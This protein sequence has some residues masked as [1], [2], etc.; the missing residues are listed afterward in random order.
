MATPER[1]SHAATNPS[2]EPP[3]RRRLGYIATTDSRALAKASRNVSFALQAINRAAKA[4]SRAVHRTRPFV[5][6]SFSAFS[7]FSA[8][9]RNGGSRPRRYGHSM[10]ATSSGSSVSVVRPSCHVRSVPERS[11]RVFA[12]RG[13]VRAMVA[14]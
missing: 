13:A 6:L 3:G 14:V 4:S 7:A 5:P 2:N 9:K 8:V 10:T 12:G 1:F 11:S